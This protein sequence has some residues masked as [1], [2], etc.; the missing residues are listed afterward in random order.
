MTGQRKSH[1]TGS[2]SSNNQTGS[3]ISFQTGSQILS[4]NY[5]QTSVE[6][7]SQSLN[8]ADSHG[9]VMDLYD[10]ADMSME[11]TNS[12]MPYHRLFAMKHS[13]QQGTRFKA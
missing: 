4:Q 9:A 7:G 12:P 1:R 2:Q 11:S 6:T 10:V 8:Q 13:L 3:Q 5:Y